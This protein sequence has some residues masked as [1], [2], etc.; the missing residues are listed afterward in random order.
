MMDYVCSTEHF[1][2]QRQREQQQQLMAF[3]LAKRNYTE[4]D[5]IA[6]RSIDAIGIHFAF[7]AVEKWNYSAI[8]S[9]AIAMA[10]SHIAEAHF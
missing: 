2:Q 10:T 6:H 3:A 9:N 8:N 4:I 5:L 1:E 7:A